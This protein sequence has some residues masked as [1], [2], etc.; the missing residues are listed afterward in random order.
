[1]RKVLTASIFALFGFVAVPANA[2]PF[3]SLNDGHSDVTPIAF[4]CGVGWTRG[5]YGRCIP[6]GGY[7]V[8]APRVYGAYGGYGYHPY[9]H[10][11]GYHPYAHAYGYHP[12]ARRYGYHPYYRRY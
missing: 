2:M 7:G 1:M 4:G 9:A 12:Y 8:A 11:Y 3:P 6:M 10:A 5:P